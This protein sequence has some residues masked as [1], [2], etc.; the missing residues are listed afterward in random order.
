M[1]RF[2]F[3]PVLSLV[4]VLMLCASLLACQSVQIKPRGEIQ[5]GIG[6]GGHR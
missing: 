5:G 1:R 4:V 2:P 3:F 6:V